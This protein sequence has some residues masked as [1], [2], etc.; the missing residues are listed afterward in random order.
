LKTLKGNLK[1]TVAHDEEE[2]AEVEE[3]RENEEEVTSVVLEPYAVVDP[4]AVV[5]EPL[6]TPPA[7]EAVAAAG[8]GDHL[9]LRADGLEFNFVK[10]FLLN[11]S[12]GESLH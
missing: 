8:C 2:E 7:C 11:S 3:C 5:V 9:A 6:D 10:D 12:K 4:H 1:F